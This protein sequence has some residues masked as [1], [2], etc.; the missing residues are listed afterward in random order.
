MTESTRQTTSVDL[1]EKGMHKGR[2][3]SLD[4]R[5][6][7]KFTAFNG[8]ASHQN[9]ARALADAGVEGTLYVDASDP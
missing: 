6:F 8:C 5:L 3:I 7:M 4:R 9:A 2:P 1:S